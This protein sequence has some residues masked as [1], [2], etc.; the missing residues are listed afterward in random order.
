MSV[1]PKGAMPPVLPA[2]MMPPMLLVHP[3]FVIGPTFYMPPRALI[4]GQDDMLYFPL[5]QHI[6]DYEPLSWFLIPAFA[7][8]DGF[9]DSY[10]HMLHN[11]QAMILNAGNGRLLCKVF[12]ASLWGPA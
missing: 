6:L 1:L 7:T 4:R 9:T 2:C 11:N 5:R 3:T 8:F 10:D 12:P